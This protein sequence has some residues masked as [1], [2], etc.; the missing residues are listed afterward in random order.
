MVGLTF[1]RESEIRRGF[2]LHTEISDI[3]NE[4][5]QWCVL[6]IM[7]STWISNYGATQKA[8]SKWA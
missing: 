3:F 1:Q 8:V 4:E 6:F 7:K 5:V 2:M